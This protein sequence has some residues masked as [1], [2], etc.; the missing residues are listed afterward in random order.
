MGSLVRV[1][2]SFSSL[3]SPPHPTCTPGWLTQGALVALW[4]LPLHNGR[5][6]LFSTIGMVPG[7]LATVTSNEAVTSMLCQAVGSFV[8]ANAASNPVGGL[9]F[10]GPRGLSV[11]AWATCRRTPLCFC[12]GVCVCRVFFFFWG[13]ISWPE[14]GARGVRL[15]VCERSSG[16][17]YLQEPGCCVLCH[18]QGPAV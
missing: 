3:L 6:H 17:Q 16:A 9:P 11:D 5:L 2:S 4:R 1:S 10:S 7:H 15:H 18:G 14:P 8:S 12:S 13:G